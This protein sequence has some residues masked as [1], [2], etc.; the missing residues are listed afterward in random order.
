MNKRDLANLLN[1]AAA[2]LDVTVDELLALKNSADLSAESNDAEARVT[3]S[4]NV[5]DLPLGPFGG[6]REKA[7][8]WL[9]SKASVIEDILSERGNDAI[10][11][12]VVADD[13]L[14]EEPEDGSE[15]E[16]WESFTD[17]PRMFYECGICD[18][19]HPADWDGDCREDA[20]RFTADAL[21]K[22]HGGDWWQD[23]RLVPMPGTEDDE[24]S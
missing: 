14:R 15:P 3:V 5:N 7:A 19:Y 6:D 17:T 11:D 22:M 2:A 23:S 18:H 8:E 4:F 21:D 12:L 1:R 13:S 9:A 16:F 20:N 10:S 24:S